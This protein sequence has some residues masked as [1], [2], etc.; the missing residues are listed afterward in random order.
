[1]GG[2]GEAMDDGQ[3]TATDGAD[4]LGTSLPEG[5]KRRG[6]LPYSPAWRSTSECGQGPFPSV[7]ALVSPATDPA[8][9]H[10]RGEGVH[11]EEI[12]GYPDS[13]GR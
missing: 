9:L 8:I 5:H 3:S 1:M 12:R 2:A 10:G 7:R 11:Y 6:G 13:R 4:Y